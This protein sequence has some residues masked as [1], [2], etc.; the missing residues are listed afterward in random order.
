MAEGSNVQDI[1][2]KKSGKAI[3][4]LAGEFLTLS[5]GDRV[6]TFSQFSERSEYSRGTL[7]NAIVS[8]TG[9]NAI[10]LEKHG[11]LG[12]FLVQKNTDLLLKCLGLSYIS[13]IMPLPYTKKYEGLATGIF[14]MF[15]GTKSSISVDIA[16]MRGSVKRILS[17]ENGRYD[18]AVTSRLSAKT[19]ISH[20]AAV[21]IIKDFGPQSYLSGQSV[22]FR[23]HSAVKITDGMRVGVDNSS[24]DH[25]ELT[26]TA[27]GDAKVELVQ[28]SYNQLMKMLLENAIDAAVWNIDNIRE[29]YRNVNYRVLACPGG[30]DETSA[31]MVTAKDNLAIRSVIDEFLNVETV[32]R[33]QRE[34]VN[35]ERYPNY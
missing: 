8:L 12:T 14:N 33:Q 17:V 11:H 28:I 5:C 18:F 26:K 16:Y 23:D 29:S 25:V 9:M 13:G 15:N 3:S 21:E 20:N 1:M 27:I 19:A 34:V 10:S 35:E 2:M 31:V 30:D 6:P 7:Q 24:L 32:L 22:V 4:F